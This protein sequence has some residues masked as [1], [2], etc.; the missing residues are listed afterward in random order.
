MVCWS[1]GLSGGGGGGRGRGGGGIIEQHTVAHRMRK[2][3]GVED[4]RGEREDL[5]GALYTFNVPLSST[6]HVI[7][8][9]DVVSSRR[10]T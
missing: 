7:C 6:S 9:R 10:L 1:G 5:N 8:T 3:K 4:G 2:K